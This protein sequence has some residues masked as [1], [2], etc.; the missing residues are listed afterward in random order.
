MSF[1]RRLVLGTILILIVAVGILVLLAER[2]LRTDL[3]ADVGAALAREARL[4]RQALPRDSLGWDEAVHRLGRASEHRVTL[5]DRGGRVRADSDFPSGRLPEL[6]NHAGR[7]EVRIA[8]AGGIGRSSR[9]SA[10]VGERLLYVALPGGP[11]VVRMAASLKQVDEVVGGAQ[12]AVGGAALLALLVGSLLAMAAARTIGRPLVELSAASRDI[13]AGAAP[14]FPRSKVP[15]IDALVGALRAMHR[16]LAD[17]FDALRRERA[18]SAA[19]VEAMVEGVIASDGTGQ[20][21]TANA[22]ARR[23]LGYPLTGPLPEIAALFRIKA[24]R[25]VVD[26][27][28]RGESIEGRE[29]EMDG[30]VLTVSARPLPGGGA[31]LVLHDITEIRRLENVRRDFVANVSHE[32]RTPLTS[33]S[34][35]AETLIDERP[36][37]V[38]EGQFLDI[39]LGNARRMQRLVD[40]LLDLSRLESGGW[41]PER[42]WVDLTWVSGEVWTAL[43]TEPE[44]RGIRLTRDVA[45]APR[46]WAD[47][48]AVRQV[49]TNLIGNAFRYAPP[50][51]EIVCRSRTTEGGVAVSVSDSG[52]GVAREHLSRIFERFYRVDSSR[53]RKEGGTGLG[54]AIVKHLVEGHG[55]RIGA[56]SEP[57]RGLTVTC[58]FPPAAESM[59]LA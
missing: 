21:I 7:P 4:V 2:S 47:P 34:G 15:E 37:A 6:E 11:G 14:R 44:A 23:L 19:I 48:D 8:L 57:G 27:V 58:W 31:V 33:I 59:K 26:A 3:E 40:D 51:S 5:I 17:R 39:I 29:L 25:A 49:L 24:A 38:T 50:G 52:P 43:G 20:V 42:E 1:A 28:Q 54:L 16:E 32:L 9:R 36:D 10:S 45:A 55:G 56:E 30:R 41:R 35:Y 46:A 53:S 12:E 22:A 13:A 18:E